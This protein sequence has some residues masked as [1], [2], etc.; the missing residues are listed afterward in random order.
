[1][2]QTTA[3]ENC[4]E[5][6]RCPKC[7]QADSFN[8][9]V[10]ACMDVTDDGTDNYS[11]VEWDDDSPVVCNEPDCQWEGEVGNLQG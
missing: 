6:M 7:G 11:N 10:T 4:L 1:M 9:R 3:N 5:G 2:T 8:I